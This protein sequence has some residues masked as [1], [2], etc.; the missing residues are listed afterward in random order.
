M[1]IIT[2]FIKR[3]PV[4]VY[5][6]LTFAISWG[7]LL[8]FGGLEGIS[9]T[10]WQSDPRLP[11]LVVAMLAGPSL[12]GLLLTGLVAGRAGYR[13]L[14]ARLLRWRVGAHWYAVALL[15]A[16]LVFAALNLALSPFS[17][18]ARPAIATADNLASFLLLGTVPALFVGFFEELGWTGFATPLLKRRH[19]VLATGLLVGVP[20]GAWHLITSDLWIA[21]AF[22]GGLPVALFLIVNGILLL[23][24]QLPAYRVLLVWVY[25][26]TDS[27]L[28]AMLMH[29]SLSACTYLF[30]TSVTG[31]TSLV[32]GFIWAATWW[33]VVA[34]VAV[35]SGGQ[36]ARQPLR[37]QVA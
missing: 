1:T 15:T 27:L 2:A 18:E 21:N 6:A 9:G 29:A 10:N 37:R 28:V 17:P 5:Y 33:A 36:L 12:A 19:G 8:G 22:S 3:H 4:P 16:P 34:G 25:A 23:I 20:W 26:R 24:G 31:A 14:L 13:D 7:G 30:G 35:A 32:H 11:F